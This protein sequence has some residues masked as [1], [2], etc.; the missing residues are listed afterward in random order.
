M[1]VPFPILWGIVAFLFSYIPTL[2]FMRSASSLINAFLLSL[3]IVLSASPIL[4]GLKKRGAPSWLAF[5][6]TL[7][8]I[9]LVFVVLVLVLVG[10]FNTL[11][12]SLPEYVA[13]MEGLKESVEELIA[14]LGI[15]QSDIEA[16]LTLIEPGAIVDLAAGF[17]AGIVGAFSDIVLIVMIIVFL[18]VDAMSITPKINYELATDQPFVRRL[19]D[20][21]TDLRQYVY[22]TTIVGLVTGV[23]DAIFF[24]IMGVPFPILWGIVAF[25]F[26]Y[27]P[28]LG[29]WLAAIPPTFMALLENG[30]VSAL[31]VF[32][33]IVVLNGIAENVVKPKYMGSG[34]NLSPFVVIFSVI[35]WSAILGP[36]G[37]I[38]SIPVTLIIKELV[39][40]MDD[41]NRWI[42]VLMSA[43]VPDDG[44]A[45]AAAGAVADEEAGQAEEA[46]PA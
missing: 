28:T 8:A 23:L 45:D 33:G 7:F 31:I 16:A 37:A 3:I 5:I 20:F 29:F 34:L 25:L 36:M 13:E 17:L 27:I 4:Y 10:S 6:V 30:P 19:A 15:E 40:E 38:L 46:T 12:E 35:F 41:Q 22:I 1:G 43:N 11:A 9:V 14:R 24:I 42:A 39:L 18:L 26:S 21:G 32:I 44:E 2:G